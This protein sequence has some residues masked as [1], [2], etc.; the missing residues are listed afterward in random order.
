MTGVFREHPIHG[1]MAVEFGGI[2]ARDV[3]RVPCAQQHAE[4]GKMGV[5]FVYAA[6]VSPRAGYV[7]FPW[8]LAGPRV[9]GHDTE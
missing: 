9:I 6:C 5:R 7:A 8:K 2:D 3:R 4:S 1:G